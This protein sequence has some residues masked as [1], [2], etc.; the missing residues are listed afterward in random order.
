MVEGN[1]RPIRNGLM[2]ARSM[3]EMPRQKFVC[4]AM[5]V[6]DRSIRLS[7]RTR[8]ASLT[9]VAAAEI[10]NDRQRQCDAGVVKDELT[11]EQNENF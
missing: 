10:D 5:N 1:D 2:I 8:W 7:A 9:T 6:T 4:R 3:I 11:T